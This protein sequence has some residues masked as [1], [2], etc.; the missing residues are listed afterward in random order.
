MKAILMVLALVGFAACGPKV[1]YDAG[2]GRP[3]ACVETD[4]DGVEMVS[5]PGDP[6]CD[7]II[8]GRH[9]AVYVA[10]RLVRRG[11]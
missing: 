11:H 9:N 8:K 4:S 1:E 2:S 6:A 7:E 5:H 3:V 10:P